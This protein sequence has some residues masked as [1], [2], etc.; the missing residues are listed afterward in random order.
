MSNSPSDVWSFLKL[1][2]VSTVESWFVVVLVGIVLSAPAHAKLY[3]SPDGNDDWS[4]Q[5]S[6][7][8][9]N[10]TNGPFATIGQACLAARSSKDKEVQVRKGTYFMRK[11]LRLSPLDSGLRLVNFPGERPLISGGLKI[12]SWKRESQNRWSTALSS[13]PVLPVRVVRSGTH[14]INASRYPK[15]ATNSYTDG[16]L[17]AVSDSRSD[18]IICASNDLKRWSRPNDVQVV[19]FPDKG[20]LNE[21]AT[22]LKIDPLEGSILL[23]PVPNAQPIREGNRFYLRNVFESLDQPGTWC[24]VGSTNQLWVCPAVGNREPQEIYVP[25]CKTLIEMSGDANNKQFLQD[26]TIA[27]FDFRDTAHA[28]NV[29]AWGP[30]ESALLLSAVQNCHITDNRFLTLGGNAV[31]LQKQSHG[32]EI[33]HNLF[34][35]IGGGGILLNGDSSNQPFNNVIADNII[36]NCGVIFKATVG[37]QCKSAR[38]TLIRNNQISNLPRQGIAVISLNPKSVSTKNVL[39]GNNITDTNRETSDSGAIYFLGRG[40][41]DTGSL[42]RRNIITNSGGMGTRKDGT[43]AFPQQTWG[44]YLDDWTSGVSVTE[45]IFNAC[46]RGGVMIHGGENNLVSNNVF[47][48]N[49][50]SQVT[51]QALIDNDYLR[52]NKFLKNIVVLNG[53]TSSLFASLSKWDPKTFGQC[54]F[55]LYFDRD[56]DGFA[57]NKKLTPVGNIGD[58]R[59]QGFD[60]HSLIGDPLLKNYVSS[61]PLATK[62][63]INPLTGLSQAGKGAGPRSR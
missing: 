61:S 14:F 23:S 55:N 59:W 20:Y 8:N 40:K 39:D 58:W 4:G 45:N 26:V 60:G 9:A 38:D 2:A 43:F 51:T 62:L 27:G 52:N 50:F 63:G 49:P 53:A 3:V 25:T 35:E 46:S 37:I 7:P 13:L 15:P 32:N 1:A 6:A 18:Q 31:S 57:T 16:W 5:L 29:F 30:V 47:I 24:Y 21:V 56:G 48:N 28:E 11:A 17:F 33:S 44:V 22:V 54:D 34:D 36:R 42:V 10:R 12:S 19:I 41:V